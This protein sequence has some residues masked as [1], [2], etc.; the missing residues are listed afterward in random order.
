VGVQGR[1][2]RGGCSGWVSHHPWCQQVFDFGG[3]ILELPISIGLHPS[4][5]VLHL[6]GGV[7]VKGIVNFPR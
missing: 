7:I 3:T 5:V 1:D 4:M 2:R 6:P